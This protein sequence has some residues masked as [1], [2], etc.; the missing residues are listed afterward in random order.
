M[1]NP[2]QAEV[3]PEDVSNVRPA[4]PTAMGP[5]RERPPSRPRFTPGSLWNQ[6]PPLPDTPGDRKSVR[7]SSP[8]RSGSRSPGSRGR[9]GRRGGGDCPPHPGGKKKTRKKIVAGNSSQEEE[10]HCV[11]Y[12]A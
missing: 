2:L 4:S 11:M 3:E 8:A 10:Q 5:T 9:S 6:D 1:W 7:A 12:S